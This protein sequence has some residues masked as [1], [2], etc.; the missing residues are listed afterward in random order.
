MIEKAVTT[1]AITKT[2]IPDQ[3]PNKGTTFSEKLRRL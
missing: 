1:A 3:L 2:A